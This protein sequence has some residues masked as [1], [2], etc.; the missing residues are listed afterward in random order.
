MQDKNK[1]PVPKVLTEEEKK[2][3]KKQHDKK[4]KQKNNQET[5]K[6]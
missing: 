4:V 5:I 6:K 3:L 1:K 2:E